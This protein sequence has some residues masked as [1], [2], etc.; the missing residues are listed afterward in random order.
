MAR[1]RLDP[2]GVSSPCTPS[3][4]A[5]CRSLPTARPSPSVTS[6]ERS[7]SATARSR[8]RSWIPPSPRSLQLLD[9][10]R[11]ADRAEIEGRMKNEV[12]ETRLFPE[13]HY[14]SRPSRASRSPRTST[15]LPSR[16]SSSARRHSAATRPGRADGLQRWPP[17]SGRLGA[18]DVQYRI[19]PVTALQG[20]IRLKDALELSCDI[21]APQEEP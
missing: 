8:R 15:G 5:S 18:A 10:V 2:R 11:K 7:A 13:I 17:L 19:K 14:E 1:Y 6:R 3:R 4:P 9:H 16:A 21:V 12:L 20:A